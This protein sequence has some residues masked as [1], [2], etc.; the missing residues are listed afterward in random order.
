MAAARHTCAIIF[1]FRELVNRLA[2][3]RHTGW[4]GDEIAGA[5]SRCGTLATFAA[6]SCRYFAHT[7]PARSDRCASSLRHAVLGAIA[8][9]GLFCVAPNGVML[10]SEKRSI[11]DPK[12]LDIHVQVSGFGR[13][14]SADISAVLKSAA[15]ELWRH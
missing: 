1:T 6:G 9:L 4:K 2:S 7:S 15:F 5:P 13:V 8:V 10:A 3:R 14:S 11:F 12:P